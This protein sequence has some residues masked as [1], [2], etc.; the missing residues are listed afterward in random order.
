MKMRKG[1]PWKARPVRTPAPT[2]TMTCNC[3]VGAISIGLSSRLTQG[4][5]KKRSAD[6]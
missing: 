6:L 1:N 3:N 2:S 5:G 4:E